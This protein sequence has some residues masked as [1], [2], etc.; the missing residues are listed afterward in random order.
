MKLTSKI[1]G[2]IKEKKFNV[3]AMDFVMIPKM[4]KE[5]LTKFLKKYV[6]CLKSLKLKMKTLK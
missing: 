6:I 1:K 2:G 3:E 4:F 5:S